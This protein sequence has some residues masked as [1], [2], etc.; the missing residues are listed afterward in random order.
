MTALIPC[1]SQ[2]LAFYDLSE[3]EEG[4]DKLNPGRRLLPRGLGRHD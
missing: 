3:K 4:G 1:N 2:V